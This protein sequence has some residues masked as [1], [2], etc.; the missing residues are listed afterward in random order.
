MRNVE[1][2]VVSYLIGC[3]ADL[4]KRSIKQLPTLVMLMRLRGEPVC[5]G[6]KRCLL[7]DL[8]ND[9]KNIFR[10]EH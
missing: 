4:A 3:R 1:Y 10:F 9:T 6:N 5:A 7:L 2:E 8:E